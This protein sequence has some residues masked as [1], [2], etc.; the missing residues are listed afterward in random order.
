MR[1]RIRSYP[2]HAPDPE[3]GRE[4]IAVVESSVNNSDKWLWE[5]VYA[6]PTE[7]DARAE[8]ETYNP[9]DYII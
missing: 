1:Y 7:E 3:K 9:Q 4:W 6:G 5:V 2:S 8:A